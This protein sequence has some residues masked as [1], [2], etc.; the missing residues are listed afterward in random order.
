MKTA[1]SLFDLVG[2][3]PL[4]EIQ[5]KRHADVRILAKME[6]CNPSGSV[7]D[8]AAKGILQDALEAGRLEGRVLLEATS[9]N[10]GIALAML[11]AELGIPV[12][13]A[14]P[15]NASEERKLI[16]RGYGATL[17]L[18]DPMAGTDGAQE[19][20]RRLV[21]EHPDRY[22]YPDQYNH[23]ANWRAH[24]TG[25]GPEIWEQTAGTVTH[26]VAGLGTSGTFYRN[27]PLSNGEG[28][29]V[30]FGS[31]G[32]SAAWSGGV[33]AYGNGCRSRHL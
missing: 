11:G 13:L 25:T 21:E 26:F 4:L 7:K 3:T 22:Y 23:D 32:Q 10:T 20:A 15:E 28:R 6:S 30:L 19:F 24:Y 9:G 1:S 5:Q 8:R 31:T 14:L 12:E 33:E 18:T 29:E 2:N 17:H 27:I 16:L